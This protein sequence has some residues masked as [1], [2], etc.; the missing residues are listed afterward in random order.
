[1]TIMQSYFDMTTIDRKEPEVTEDV[2]LVSFVQKNIT[3][4]L[5]ISIDLKMH[6][7][8]L[9]KRS[10]ENRITLTLHDSQELLKAKVL[11]RRR[12]IEILKRKVEAQRARVYGLKKDQSRDK[13]TQIEHALTSDAEENSNEFP[14]RLQTEGLEEILYK[15][16]CDLK[17]S[18]DTF[19]DDEDT[20]AAEK[21]ARNS[22]KLRQEELVLLKAKRDRLS[23]LIE[24]VRYHSI[25][26]VITL[27]KLG[28][29]YKHFGILEEL[30]FS[31]KGTEM[32]I[33]P[34]ELEDTPID[35]AP[36]VQAANATFL[37]RDRMCN[38]R[39][40]NADMARTF[41][42]LQYILRIENLPSSFLPVVDTQVAR[43][44]SPFHNLNIDIDFG[45]KQNFREGYTLFDLLY[46]QFNTLMRRYLRDPDSGDMFKFYFG[47]LRELIDHYYLGKQLKWPRD[48]L[49]LPAI[50]SK[51]SIV[52]SNLVNEMWI[53]DQIAMKALE[54][55]L[56]REEPEIY[57]RKV[58]IKTSGPDGFEE[59]FDMVGFKDDEFSRPNQGG[60]STDPEFTTI[61]TE[62][63]DRSSSSR[64]SLGAYIPTVF[65]YRK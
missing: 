38:S 51:G 3:D 22:L 25:L 61:E 11:R 9:E 31:F 62:S 55:V 14:S 34:I 28:Q 20:S 7:Q 52:F 37:L 42:A 60:E 19:I 50:A 45:S 41:L 12:E 15:W 5:K 54:D 26:R 46:L 23:K 24:K 47:Y 1:M 48:K 64:W 18:L 44:I 6:L 53:D 33:E 57:S 43:A 30:M 39:E 10:S 40:A 29:H 27:F 13:G 32:E 36:I 56:L 35:Q 63:T 16:R 2:Q 8:Q 59:E 21:N 17:Q 58:R 4:C 49:L 65:G